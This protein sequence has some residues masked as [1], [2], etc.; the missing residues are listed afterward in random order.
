MRVEGE[1]VFD[2]PRREVWD[3]IQDPRAIAGIV[4]G[5]ED[6]ERV[7]DTE[8]RSSLR[9][10]KGFLG[11]RYDVTVGLAEVAPPEGYVLV[12]DARGAFGDA[13]GTVRIALDEEGPDRTRM[14][15]VAALDLPAPAAGLARRKIEGGGADATAFRALERL[16]DERRRS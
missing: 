4:P 11:A 2:A 5:V 14:R 7:S 16:L 12:L 13:A 8:Y 3:L 9:I 6:L 15:Y 1:H 10:G